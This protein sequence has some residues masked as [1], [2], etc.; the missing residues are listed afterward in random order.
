MGDIRANINKM[1]VVAISMM[2]CFAYAAFGANGDKDSV[3]ADKTDI[4]K[5][6]KKVVEKAVKKTVEKVSEEA[7][8]KAAE[9][10][11]EKATEE[12]VEAVEKAAEKVAEKVTE[13]AV[14]KAAEKAVEKAE[15]KAAQK[16]EL[17]AKR[18]EGWWE[19]TNVN[20]F[21][22]VIDIDKIDGAAQSFTANVF[23]RLNWKDKRLAHA[24]GVK[25]IPLTEVWNPD[26]LIVNRGGITQ[27][28]LPEVVKVSADGTVTYIQRYTGPLSQPLKLS[29]FPFDQHDFTIQ[30]VS[31]G[32]TPQEVQFAPAPAI[33]DP[34]IIGGAMYHE[35]SLPDWKVTE[36]TAEVRPYK[37]TEDI[38]VAGFVFEFTAKRYTVYYVWQ[39]I[40]PLI[41]IVMMSWGSLYIDPSN[42]GAQIGVATSSMLTLIAYRFMLG[43]LIPRL[44]YMTR[45]D[46]FTLGSTFLVFLTLAE[47]IVTTN[48]ALREKVKIAIE[49]DHWC[50][51]AFPTVFILWSVWSL[52]L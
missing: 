44:P 51:F 8:E 7:V 24:G 49:V 48:L 50:R 31:P 21:V 42:A 45:L 30:F 28:S 46:Y 37:P 2:C 1:V 52:F 41:L 23:V 32:A 12:A 17:R 11:M 22:F 18:P 19:P 4:E 39:V 40:V 15:E 13:E 20:F 26:V 38:E 43:N 5:A 36:Y 27:K 6:A 16:A 29:K 35:L 10:A 25:T 9:K 47:V 34:K 14:E 3:N 33:R